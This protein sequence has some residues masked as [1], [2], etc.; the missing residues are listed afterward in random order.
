MQAGLGKYSSCVF[1]LLLEV[2]DVYV[3][4]WMMVMLILYLDVCIWCK[5]SSI[6]ST[7]LLLKAISNIL[8]RFI[9]ED[10]KVLEL[11]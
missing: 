10:W 6:V 4:S 2:V 8:H 9:T 7:I 11:Y 1:W 3:C 5:H